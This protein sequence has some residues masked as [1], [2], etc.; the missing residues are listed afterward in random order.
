[1][2]GAQ[3][4]RLVIIPLVLPLQ[5]NLSEIEINRQQQHVIMYESVTFLLRRLWHLLVICLFSGRG[6]PRV[7]A[8]LSDRS[9]VLVKNKT[10]LNA[11]RL[12]K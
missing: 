3:K 1:M 4:N 11:S 10:L 6:I 5:E 8:G 7:I 12:D 9:G 2:Y